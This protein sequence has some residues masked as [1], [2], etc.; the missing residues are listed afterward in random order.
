MSSCGSTRADTNHDNALDS[1]ELASACAS[2]L[3]PLTKHEA[4]DFFTKA[5]TNRDGEADGPDARPLLG[6]GDLQGG[7][8]AEPAR[9]PD[10]FHRP[11][12][13]VVPAARAVMR[14]ACP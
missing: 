2:G 8:L 7:G 3:L 5:D 4:N 14:L 10:V 1:E 12:A 9:H 13:A 11:G 6:V